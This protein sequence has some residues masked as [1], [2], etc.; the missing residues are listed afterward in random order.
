MLIVVAKPWSI[1]CRSAGESGAVLPLCIF[2]AFVL[3]L[4]GGLAIDSII[5]GSSRAQHQHTAE[6]VALAALRA[7]GNPASGQ[8]LTQLS[9]ARARAEEIAGINVFLSKGFQQNNSYSEDIGDSVPGATG[10][11]QP[12]IWHTVPTYSAGV[13]QGAS[14]CPCDT[15]G[16][17]AGPCFEGL[18]FS[19]PADLV[20]PVNAF[21]AELWLKDGSP[22]R[23]LFA[24]LTGQASWSF[25][26]KA[27]ATVK[28]THGVFL[29]DL[30]KS[31]HS[32][33]H[34][35]WE[36]A[37]AGN[38]P[39]DKATEYALHMTNK[40]CPADESM[41]CNPVA[42]T[43]ASSCS[44]PPA[45]RT[46]TDCDFFGGWQAGETGDGFAGA[47][48]NFDCPD[49]TPRVR[50]A[51][52]IR[53]RHAKLDYRC[54]EVGAYDDGGV[55]A[56]G[57]SYLVDAYRGPIA[58]GAIYEGPEPLTTML[59]TVNYAADQLKKRQ[60]PGDLLGLIGV[61]QSAK[62]NLR[63]LDLSAPATTI[64]TEIDE[65]SNPVI[66]GGTIGRL[67]KRNR[68]HFFFPRDRNGFNLID[69]LAAAVEQ[70]DAAVGSENAEA[71]VAVLT[72]GLVSCST[73][74]IESCSETDADHIKALIDAS[75][76]YINAELVPRNIKFH[77]LLNG[78][79]SGVSTLVRKGNAAST[80]DRC[81]TENEVRQSGLSYVDFDPT[82]GGSS[83]FAAL[84]KRPSSA[85]YPY[86]LKLY[87]GVAAT[88]GIFG[89][90][91]PPCPT[92]SA[93][94]GKSCETGGIESLL[95]SKCSASTAG[96]GATIGAQPSL[97]DSYGRLSCD[98]RCRD[99]RTQGR[100]HIDRIF[101]RNPYVLVQ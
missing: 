41:P 65:I 92:A 67:T 89:P 43:T 18:D 96:L 86:P 48:F 94:P 53:T 9:T 87:E 6:Y 50:T 25:S 55:A 11:I 95:D 91:R 66:D 75:V 38:P 77:L 74:G 28:P 34:L 13:C 71:F 33:T 17:W 21:H 52:F 8:E 101:E 22:I 85:F 45:A 31:S 60:V 93:P 61:D 4:F 68:D 90:F 46:P 83:P 16:N 2:F 35:P 97:I 80:A 69:G 5:V 79:I 81:M 56:T 27:T 72:D 62:I 37:G 7:F 39:F 51:S 23:T 99:F 36:R 76:D 1:R 47:I 84:V 64:F 73:R 98:P 49:L 88:G 12:G 20:R 29:V 32:E 14:P 3:L 82:H 10:R 58:G 44:R 59:A 54:Y 40:S 42:P 24:K 100:A 19:N 57:G 63:T 15:A 70:L 78:D 26:S 30:S